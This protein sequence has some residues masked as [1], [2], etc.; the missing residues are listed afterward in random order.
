MDAF[1]DGVGVVALLQQDD[2]FD[3]VGIVDNCAVWRGGWLGRS[4]RGGFW[5]PGLTVAMS[6]IRMAAP[7]AFL[8]TVFSMSW[9]LVKRPTDWTLICCAPCSMKLPPPLVLLLAICCSTWAMR[10]AVGDQL[11]GVELDLVLLGRAAEAGDVDHALDALEG[12]LEG[13]VFE[14]LLLHHVVGGVGAFEGVPVDLAD[15]AP[16]GAHLRNKIGG[17]ADLAEALEHVLAIDVAGGVVVEDEHQAGEAGQRGGAEMGEVGNAGHLDL[18]R[19]GDLALDL[20]G[21]AARPLGDD[22]DVVVGDVGVGFDG[23]ARKR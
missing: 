21:A 16:V 1:E 18:D 5:G 19:D 20:F 3:G 4:G 6:L 22:L 13:P 7:L 2:A 9:T 17:Q 8:T 23:Q 11:L 10:E 15:G 12:L 14:R